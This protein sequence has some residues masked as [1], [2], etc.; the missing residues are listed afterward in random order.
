M[1][2]NQLKTNLKGTEGRILKT[3]ALLREID[4]AISAK[5][6]DMVAAKQDEEALVVLKS[7]ENERFVA[8]MNRRENRMQDDILSPR[9]FTTHSI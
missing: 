5:R 4:K 8:E 1:L 6:A 7:K 2:K 3:Q 9:P